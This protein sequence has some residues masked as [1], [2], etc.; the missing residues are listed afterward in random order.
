MLGGSSQLLHVR[1]AR[2]AEGHKRS[3][4]IFCCGIIKNMGKHSFAYF[5]CMHGGLNTKF[6]Y[7]KV[8]FKLESGSCYLL[9]QYSHRVRSDKTI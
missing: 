7:F 8:R 5:G 4:K 2:A 9:K 6:Y 1:H 3:I